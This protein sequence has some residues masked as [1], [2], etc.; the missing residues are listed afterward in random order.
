MVAVVKISPENRASILYLIRWILIALVAGVIGS[1]LVGL[2]EIALSI[3]QD[4]FLRSRL[5][6]PIVAILGAVITGSLIYRVEPDA[7]G[8]GMPTYI[9]GLNRFDGAFPLSATIMKIPAS[10]ITLAT[11]GSGGLAGPLG[12]IS[13]GVLSRVF[14]HVDRRT[15]AVC[16]VAAVIGTLFHSPIGGG[17]FAVEIVQRANMRYRDLFPSVLSSAIAVWIAR[18]AGWRALLS[19]DAP[20]SPIPLSTMGLLLLL[21]VCVGLL[22]GMFTRLYALVVRVFKRNEGNAL[23]KVV[24]GAAVASVLVQLINPRLAGIAQSITDAVFMDD[25]L[26]IFGVLPSE[27]PV[28]VAALVMLLVR[29]VATCVTIGSGMSAGLLGPSMTI[30]LLAGYAWA[31]VFGVPPGSTLFYACLAVGCAGILAGSMNVPIA[32]AVMTLELFGPTFGLPA[33]LAVVVGFQINRH[34]TVYDF[35]LSGSGHGQRIPAAGESL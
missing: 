16:G 14:R 18:F 19:V 13:S 9:T 26:A 33:G 21:A 12:M 30:G 7:A 22:G 1:L 32:A 27:S 11:F 17:I 15:A 24:V 34:R 10:F 8:E 3:T 2:F 31:Y 25:K 5:P 35:A 4:L 28:F 29:A 6:I 20:G 23:I